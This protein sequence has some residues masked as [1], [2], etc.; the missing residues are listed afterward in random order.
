MTSDDVWAALLRFH[1]EV[2]LPD[3]EQVLSDACDS[4]EQR[5]RDDLRAGFD[6]LTHLA[7]GIAHAEHR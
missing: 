7:A 2:F 6:A 4:S 1:R 5:L 3:F